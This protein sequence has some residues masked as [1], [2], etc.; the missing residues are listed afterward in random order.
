MKTRE[1]SSR[2]E[3]AALL[4]RQLNQALHPTSLVV[5]MQ[6]S[7]GQLGAASGTVPAELRSFR[8]RCRLCPRLARRGQPWD[9]PPPESGKSPA[10]ER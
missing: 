6:T 7:E 9:V 5:Y 4:E 3:L 10:W 2:Q 8:P 1:A